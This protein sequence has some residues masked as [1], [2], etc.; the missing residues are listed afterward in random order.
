MNNKKR[1]LEIRDEVIELVKEKFGIKFYFSY[2]DLYKIKDGYTVR[3]LNGR[4]SNSLEIDSD[5]LNRYCY[6][7][8]SND[9]SILKELNDLIIKIDDYLKELKFEGFEISLNKLKS[10]EIFNYEIVLNIKF[11]NI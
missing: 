10:G 1:S 4:I 3:R 7:N 9:E 6:Y 5:K 11:K 2:N 8:I